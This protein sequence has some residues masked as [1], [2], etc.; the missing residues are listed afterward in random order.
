[1]DY[2]HAA[3]CRR[4]LWQRHGVFVQLA[5]ALFHEVHFPEVA[6]RLQCNPQRTSDIL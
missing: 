2:V 5:L 6:L 3:F 4:V 1:M